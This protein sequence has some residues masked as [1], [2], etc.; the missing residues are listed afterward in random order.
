MAVK[1]TAGHRGTKGSD[2]LKVDKGKAVTERFA[3]ATRLL[4]SGR[5]KEA[6]EHF[7]DLEINPL[8]KTNDHD[9]LQAALLHGMCLLGLERF[10]AA[11]KKFRETRAIDSQN[12]TA[13][14][15]LAQALATAPGS[16]KTK[17]INSKEANSLLE[18]SEIALKRVE[19]ANERRMLRESIERI[20]LKLRPPPQ[21]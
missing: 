16:T 21:Q 5:Y 20:R 13:T 10:P 1:M 12:L 15:M 9:R 8:V 11:I 3:K 19:D 2:I 17:S 18:G 7:A 4:N 14:I 6:V